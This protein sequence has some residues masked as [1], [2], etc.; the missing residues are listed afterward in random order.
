MTTFLPIPFTRRD[1]ILTSVCLAY[2]VLSVAIIWSADDLGSGFAWCFSV[3]FGTVALAFIRTSHRCFYTGLF[4]AL[5]FAAMMW[6]MRDNSLKDF[7]DIDTVVFGILVLLP[8]AMAWV[9][10]KLRRNGKD[11]A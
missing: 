2:V 4:T 11:A 3:L 10:S 6:R 8:I 9:V 5:I 7:W 1:Q